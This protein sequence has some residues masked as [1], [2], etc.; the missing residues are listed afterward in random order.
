MYPSSEWKE[1]K[2]MDWK[3][4]WEMILYGRNVEHMACEPLYPGHQY[5]SGLSEVHT[6]GS[7]LLHTPSTAAWPEL[8]MAG[9]Q[10]GVEGVWLQEAVFELQ[11]GPLAS[12][13]CQ[14][15]WQ[16]GAGGMWLHR[17]VFR[18]RH[19]TWGLPPIVMSTSMLLHAPGSS[20]M[21]LPKHDSM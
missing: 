9:K 16:C 19:G 2:Q 11:C 5:F 3:E 13:Q 8:C 10:H 6:L 12:Q 14:G 4:P 20:S 17:A 21:P 15:K 18:W 1:T 7:T